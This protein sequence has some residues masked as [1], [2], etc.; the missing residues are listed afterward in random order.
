MR[1]ELVGARVQSIGGYGQAERADA[2]VFRPAT[3]DEIRELL[4]LARRTARKVV[5]RGAGRSYGDA[6]MLGEG[7]VIDITRMNRI[8]DW[9]PETGRIE[10]EPG[11]TIEDLWRHCLEDGWWPPVVSGTMFPTLGGA[12][13]M[14][15]HGKN[16]FCAGTLGEHVTELDL[17]LADGSLR[18][19]TPEDELFYA[20]ISGF[21]MF[22]VIVRVVL[23]M[24]RI[25]NGNVRVLATSPKSWEEQFAEFERYEKEADYMVSWVDCFAKGPEAGRGQFHAAWYERGKDVASLLPQNQDLPDTILGFFPKSSVWRFLKPLNNRT[26]MRIL[27]WAK[28]RAS[29]KLGD[30]KTIVQ[31]LVGFS[32]LLDYVPRWRDAYLPHGFIQY[33]TFVPKEHARRV[34]ARQV[35]MQQEAGLESFLGVLKRHRPDRFLVSHAVD[36][37]SL[38]LD[39]KVTRGNRERLRELCHRMN[40]LVLEAGGRFYL[41]KDSTL[42]P[43]DA[44]AYLGEE[45]LAKIVSLKQEL[46]PEGLFSTGLSRRVFNF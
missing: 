9:N 39:F 19:L 6:S 33:Q 15:I 34:F 4:D 1:F 23:R 46:D 41:A 31:G 45:T 8:L 37:Y 22:G 27:N 16:N 42:R 24:K 36:G 18:T 2:Y 7:V 3:V 20:A 21:G 12:L 32:F 38:A 43:S 44:R 40:E 14:N 10:C 25:E 29:R 5:L 11:V 35:E 17:L 30:H 13:G 28:D 26:G